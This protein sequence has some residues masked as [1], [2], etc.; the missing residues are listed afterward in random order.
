MSNLEKEE[1]FEYVYE[2]ASDLVKRKYMRPVEE[3]QY[4]TTIKPRGYR[5]PGY[6]PIKLLDQLHGKVTGTG[7]LIEQTF[8]Y[9]DPMSAR[10]WM[11]IVKQQDYQIHTSSGSI[12]LNEAVDAIKLGLAEPPWDGKTLEVVLLGAADARKEIRLIRGILDT[13]PELQGLYVCLL[14]ISQPLLAVAEENVANAFKDEENVHILSVEGDFL[15]LPRYHDLFFKPPRNEMRRIFVMLGYTFSNLKSELEFVRYSLGSFN[16]GDLFITDYGIAFGPAKD[17][18][19]LMEK[20]PYLQPNNHRWRQSFK[21]FI[22]GPLQRYR[23]DVEE[24]D[25]NPTLDNGLTVVDG[26]YC[27]DMSVTVISKDSSRHIFHMGRVK[28]YDTNKL[29]AAV[30]DQG[31][32]QITGWT[33][34]NSNDRGLYLWRKK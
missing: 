13:F 3:N 31:W 1:K 12:P 14:D 30:C 16:P 18:E 24:I 20:D 29:V 23:K 5:A 10:D 34:G 17:K 11:N 4:L 8:S 21:E 28:R 26:S 22:A 9:V 25:F 7:G 2:R 15:E 6:D 32:D 33:Y 27:V 19:L